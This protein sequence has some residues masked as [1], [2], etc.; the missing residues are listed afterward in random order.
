MARDS[1]KV[2][3]R[4]KG[5]KVQGFKSSRVQ[6]KDSVRRLVANATADQRS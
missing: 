1:K 5:S 2:Q 4:F 6:G 3:R